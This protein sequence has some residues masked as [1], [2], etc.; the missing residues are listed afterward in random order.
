[1]R[2]PTRN[3]D[4]VTVALVVVVVAS[5]ALVAWVFASP[6]D[7][8]FQRINATIEASAKIDGHTV[9]VTGTT[10]LPDGSLLDWSL[11]QERY[12]SADYPPAGQVAVQGGAFAFDADLTKL[13]SGS[14]EADV[15]FSCNYGTV[16]PDHVTGVVG[17]QCE[18]LGG[19]QVYVDSP[20]DSKQLFVPVKFAVP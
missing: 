3:G 18:H 19:E 6:I 17:D 9:R 5:V 4:L 7:L 12:F 8:P 13:E 2:D 1:M 15:T 14:A 10:N 16:Q 11:D 20:G